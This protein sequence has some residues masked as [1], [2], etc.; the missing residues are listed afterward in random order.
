M[1]MESGNPEIRMQIHTKASTK[2]IIK[3]D[4]EYISGQME[5]YIE[6]LLK[7][8]LNMV[9]VWLLIRMVKL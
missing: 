4:L 5:P 3:M 9:K 6:D 1:D 8:I 7:T 2:K